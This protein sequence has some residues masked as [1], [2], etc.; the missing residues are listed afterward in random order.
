MYFN[1]SQKLSL[2]GK[3]GMKFISL[4]GKIGMKFISLGG[5]IGIKWYLSSKCFKI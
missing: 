3:I 2:G 4:G 5:K 1:F